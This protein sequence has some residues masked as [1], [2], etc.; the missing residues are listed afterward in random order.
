MTMVHDL[1]VD[2]ILSWRDV[3]RHRSLS[4]LPG[5]LSHL[6]S[7]ELLDFP[8]LRAHQLDPFCMFLTQLSAIALHRQKMDDPH[9]SEETWR[10]FL[11]TLSSGQH[12]PWSLIVDDLSK[13]AFLQAPVPEGTLEKWK[14]LAEHP[15]DIDV[16]ITAK[17]HDLKGSM[18]DPSDICL[19]FFSLV[20]LQTM[21]GY[22][23]RGYYGIS[24]MKSGYGNRPR[25]GLSPDISLGARFRRD[26][27]VLLKSWPEV[28]DRGYQDDGVA[29][30]WVE[31]WDGSTSLP[32][33]ELAPHFIEICWRV[34]CCLLDGTRVYCKYTTTKVR[35]CLAEIETGDVGD[36]WIP[37]ERDKGALSVGGKGFHYVLLSRLLFGGDFEPAAAQIPVTEDVDPMLFIAW[38]LARGQSK[39]EGLH[40][41]LIAL[42]GDVRRR[43]GQPLEKAK[44]GS[45]SREAI[46]LVETMWK[47]V[48][49]PAVQRINQGE[50]IGP[51]FDARV[52]EI[53][54]EHLFATSQMSD[55]EAR[56]QWLQQLKAIAEQELARAIDRCC[57]PV[58]RRYKA[59]CASESMFRS[60]LKKRFPDL[61]AD[62][63]AVGG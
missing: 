18:L 49:S 46:L 55:E 20:T 31:P 39:T 34:R 27:G 21:Q 35:R 36:P 38:A 15:D 30:V 42:S 59:I 50:R 11:L 62:D 7:G 10:D 1:L 56:L 48:L 17:G 57:V 22:P 9:L 54:F 26:V 41:R 2:P 43:L 24:R 16:L 3:R 12:E 63:V 51:T 23:A 28:L 14:G 44:L 13:P 45:R 47:N 53:F 33:G 52:D 60:L 61:F 32:M 37:I 4:T 40:K 58:A 19:W 6:A 8:R 5:I 25:I 29:L